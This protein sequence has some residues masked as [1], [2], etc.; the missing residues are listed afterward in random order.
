MKILTL[1]FILLLSNIHLQASTAR[2]YTVG[3][4]SIPFLPY[5]NVENDHYNGF[6]KNL[7]DEFAKKEKI[8]FKYIPLPLNRLYSQFLMHKLDFKIP[9]SPLWQKNKKK[10]IKIYY[11]SPV[12][13]YVDGVMV[14]KTV[15][16]I[17][18]IKT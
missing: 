2:E 16:N 13:S 4:E 1:F 9:A 3:V 12:I 8:T 5:S 11:S 14:K 17:K 15:T 6:F 10:D 7:L 18:Q